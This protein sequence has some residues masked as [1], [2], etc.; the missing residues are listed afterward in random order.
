M[1]TWLKSVS[2]D[3]AQND[4]LEIANDLAVE[5]EVLGSTIGIGFGT[6][7]RMALETQVMYLE[8]RLHFEMPIARSGVGVKCRYLVVKKTNPILTSVPVLTSTAFLTDPNALYE[9]GDSITE[10]SR[11]NR[12]S[13]RSWAIIK[14]GTLKMGEDSVLSGGRIVT[15]VDRVLH[16]PGFKIRWKDYSANSNDDMFT[17][18]L[19]FFAY[20]I[21]TGESDAATTDIPEY[22]AKIR[23]WFS[24]LG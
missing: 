17:G 20:F 21:N 6:G 12:L 24:P 8:I 18:A 5:F 2:K 16:I 3:V 10:L 9:D 19:Y 22:S 14:Q 13:R 1:K 23:A 4:M 7:S 11:R 15:H